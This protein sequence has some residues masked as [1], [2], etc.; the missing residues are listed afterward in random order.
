[1]KCRHLRWVSHT[2]TAA[3]K[4]MRVGLAQ[5]ALQALA[6]HQHTNFH[7]LFTCDEAWMFSAHDHRTMW[8]ASWNDVEEIGRPPHFQQKTKV[9]IFFDGTA[10][11]K[12]AILPQRHKMN[13]TAFMGCVLEPLVE[14]CSADDRQ[15]HEGKSMLHFGNGPI[16]N[17]E[18]VQ[19]HL[20]GLGFKRLED[21]PESL[22]LSPCDFFVFG[23]MKGNFRGQ[24]FDSLDGL[25][26]AVDSFWEGYL[27]MSCR[28]FFKNG[29][30]TYDYALKAA[31]NML[32]EHY[33]T[34][35]LL[36]Q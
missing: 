4:V 11:R 22:D 26:D 33:K 2:M 7:F 19:D 24:R 17:A 34:T 27:L 21:P 20:T 8:V 6:K 31:E 35:N 13:S 23:P 1:M 9:T 12:I 3:Q 30:G 10:E 15:I 28:R 18:A 16:H 14:M 25:F 5:S 36:S 29:Y 32:S